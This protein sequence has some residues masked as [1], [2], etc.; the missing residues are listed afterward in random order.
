MKQ[1]REQS[2]EV[3]RAPPASTGAVSMETDAE[4]PSETLPGKLRAPSER[5]RTAEQNRDHVHKELLFCAA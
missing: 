5:V 3:E 2:S 4:G 1:L